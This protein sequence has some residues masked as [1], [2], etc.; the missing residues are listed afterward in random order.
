[1]GGAAGSV[2]VVGAGAAVVA[3]TTAVGAAELT[4]GWPITAGAAGTTI[5]GTSLDTVAAAS[6][7]VLPFTLN[8]P[9]E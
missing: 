2:W 6:A 4:A 8:L 1:M 5:L 9:C 3:L 7:M